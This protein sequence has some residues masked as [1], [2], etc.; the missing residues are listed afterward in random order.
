MGVPFITLKA[1]YEN[2]PILERVADTCF[3]SV[4][5]FYGREITIINA[6][7][8]TL[9]EQTPQTSSMLTAAMHVLLVVPGVIFGSLARFFALFSERASQHYRI[10]C[11]HS[12]MVYPLPRFNFEGF[13]LDESHKELEERWEVLKTEITTKY[14]WHTQENIAEFDELITRAYKEGVYIFSEFWRRSCQRSRIMSQN[15][16]K[17][18]SCPEKLFYAGLIDMYREIRGH[19]LEDRHSL[20][21]QEEYVIE[22]YPHLGSQQQDCFFTPQ[23]MQYKWR[24]M[25]NDI[26]H[27][28]DEYNV[29]AG[30][31]KI[32][33]L[34]LR[35]MQPDKALVIEKYGV[36]NAQF[37]SPGKKPVERS[38]NSESE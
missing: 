12:S 37:L 35:W 11:Q 8:V 3:T 14:D 24:M 9:D 33:P 20:G 4:R 23:D 36:G 38:Y 32:N 17:R 5:Y 19:K 18:A 2:K 16:A 21:D 34:F 1:V 29:R 30:I 13:S 15:L 22:T 27:K 31:K 26:C 7:K 6:D 10:A 28:V 25:Y